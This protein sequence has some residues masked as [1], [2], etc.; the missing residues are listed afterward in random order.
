MSATDDF[1]CGWCPRC[2][3]ILSF[4][5]TGADYCDFCGTEL[6]YS[7][8]A[9]RMIYQ[10]DKEIGRYMEMTDLWRKGLLEFGE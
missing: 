10:C 8:G 7:D 1:E 3:A 4:K 2:E 5:G 6:D 9:S